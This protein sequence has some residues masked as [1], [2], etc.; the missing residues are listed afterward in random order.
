MRQLVSALQEGDELGDRESLKTHSYIY[1]L[2]Y[3][4]LKQSK[5]LL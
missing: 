3:L 5:H 4:Y 1:A 2:T